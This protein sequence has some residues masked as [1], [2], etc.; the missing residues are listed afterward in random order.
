[1]EIGLVIMEIN[2][3]GKGKFL[4]ETY[5]AFPHGDHTKMQSSKLEQCGAITHKA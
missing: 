4:L 2:G 3:N 5:I 1:V